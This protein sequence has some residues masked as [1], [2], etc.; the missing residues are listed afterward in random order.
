MYKLPNPKEFSPFDRYVALKNQA[1]QQ[2]IAS[3]DA[4]KTTRRPIRANLAEI[5]TALTFI[6]PEID[7]LGSVAEISL[8]SEYQQ[9][10]LDARGALD[11]SDINS[12]FA[13]SQDIVENRE[14]AIAALYSLSGEPDQ[15]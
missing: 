12:Y 9:R 15:P 5:A 14:L 1:R 2:L 6:Q 3:L 11:D 13:Y 7:D 8:R 10:L 4:D